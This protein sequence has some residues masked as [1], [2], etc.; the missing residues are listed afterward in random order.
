MTKK[1][2]ST[3]K[4]PF[5]SLAGCSGAAMPKSKKVSYGRSACGNIPDRMTSVQPCLRKHDRNKGVFQSGLN[6]VKLLYPEKFGIK[7]S[8]VRSAVYKLYSDNFPPHLR[9]KKLFPCFSPP[10]NGFLVCGTCASEARVIKPN[11]P[12]SL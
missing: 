9:R 5:L 8:G 1:S 7:I 6:W 4:R 3:I 12:N 2:K 10:T 11:F